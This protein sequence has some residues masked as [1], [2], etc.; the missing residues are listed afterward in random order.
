M[1]DYYDYDGAEERPFP[2]LANLRVQM[3]S[4]YAYRGQPIYSYPLMYNN[5]VRS[6]G[7]PAQYLFDGR[8]GAPR[9]LVRRI[10]RR[11]PLRRKEKRLRKVANQRMMQQEKVH[12]AEENTDEEEDEQVKNLG[13]MALLQ[14]N[15]Y[16]EMY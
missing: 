4:K 12:D 7:E 8:R 11:L 16:P 10:I 5:H 9:R 14:K 2:I 1:D 13:N 15:H 3:P 6:L